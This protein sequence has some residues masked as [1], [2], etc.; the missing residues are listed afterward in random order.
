MGAV[1]SYRVVLATTISTAIA[2][3]F[4]TAVATAAATATASQTL[5]P[6]PRRPAAAAAASQTLPL[7]PRWPWLPLEMRGDGAPSLGGCSAQSDGARLP[8]DVGVGD[9]LALGERLREP[10]RAAGERRVANARLALRH[11][12]SPRRRGRSLTRAPCRLRR[13]GRGARARLCLAHER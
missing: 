2:S 4:A 3:A 8:L 7:R 5:P 1:S 10:Q 6:R 13:S 11:L 12:G 9:A